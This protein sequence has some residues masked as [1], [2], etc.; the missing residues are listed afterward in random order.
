MELAAC[1]APSS[2]EE[3]MKGARETLSSLRCSRSDFHELVRLLSSAMRMGCSR[4]DGM[5]GAMETDTGFGGITRREELAMEEAKGGYEY[6][7]SRRSRRPSTMRTH[8]HGACMYMYACNLESCV[9]R[10]LS[11]IRLEIVL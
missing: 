9:I 2:Y 1:L 10:D 4:L 11:I 6:S 8:R 7:Q 5:E 3:K